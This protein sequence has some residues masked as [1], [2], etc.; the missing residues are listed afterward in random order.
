MLPL[1]EFEPSSP[2]VPKL[3][4][5]S[6]SGVGMISMWGRNEAIGSLWSLRYRQGISVQ[7]AQTRGKG[8]IEIQCMAYICS[9]EIVLGVHMGQCEAYGVS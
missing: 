4:V 6:P 5:A 8:H 2:G 7:G 9:I 3:R 1:T